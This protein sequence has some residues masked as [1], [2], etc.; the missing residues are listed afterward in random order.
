MNEVRMYEA[1]VENTNILMCRY[2]EY[3]TTP[4]VPLQAECR[5]LAVA[6]GRILVQDYTQPH[7]A[8]ECIMPLR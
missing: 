3:T 4:F 7:P 1:N 8:Y 6:K 5:V 2:R